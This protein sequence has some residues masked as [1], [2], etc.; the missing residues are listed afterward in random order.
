MFVSPDGAI[1]LRDVAATMRTKREEAQASRIVDLA[2]E[3][4]DI[5]QDLLVKAANNG[6]TDDVFLRTAL[7]EAVW[8]AIY[9]GVAS[10]KSSYA[11][12]RN[13][14]GSLESKMEFA[15]KALEKAA[16]KDAF[17]R[18]EAAGHV[19]AMVQ[20]MAEMLIYG[21]LKDNPRGFNGIAKHYAKYGSNDEDDTAFT[22][23]SGLHLGTGE[24]AT[25]KPLQSIFL[26]GWG[27]DST[28][29]FYPEGSNSAGVRVG[30][31]KPVEIT[32]SDVQ[33]KT[34]EGY[35]QHFYWDLGLNIM[36]WRKNGRLCNIDSEKHQTGTSAEIK[37]AAEAFFRDIDVLTGR[38]DETGTKQ[39]LYMSKMIWE[40]ARVFSAAITRSNAVTEKN[41]EGHK[42]RELNGIVVRINRA[43][44]V[45]ETQVPQA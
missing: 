29:C 6:D 8:T 38:V 43:Q 25:G 11:H 26:V 36:D 12:V 33:T 10:S 18:R 27:D 35:V 19:D 45:V 31:M 1:S 16:N 28:H 44:N 17:L 15:K 32:N 37:A 22:V 2:L 3:R 20:A 21:N 42:V 34:F 14:A 41:V 39:V 24:T 23:V 9:E 7:P 4:N 13:T 5:M 30:E 40:Q